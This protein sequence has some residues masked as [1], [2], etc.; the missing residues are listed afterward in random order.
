LVSALSERLSTKPDELV[1]RVGRLQGEIRDLQRKIAEERARQAAG[2]AAD[3][4]A[5]VLPNGRQIVLQQLRDF[6]N[7]DLRNVV[8]A[9]LQRNGDAVV[10]MTSTI[11]EKVNMVVRV[12][13][14]L[15]AKGVRAGELMKIAAPFIGGKGGGGPTQA[16]GGGTNPAGAAAALAA[17]R[18]AVADGATN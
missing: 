13:E 7:N 10:A 17:L 12:P 15:N 18:A 4:K 2:A 8:N 6:D 1:D 5:E 14:S 9:V 11:D 3:V 16:Q